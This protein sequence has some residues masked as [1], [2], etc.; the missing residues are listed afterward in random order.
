[1]AV[2]YSGRRGCLAGQIVLQG[3]RREGKKNPAAGFGLHS[4]KTKRKRVVKTEQ[5]EQNDD[6]ADD[7][8]FPIIIAAAY[9]A[10]E[11]HRLYPG[12]A[13]TMDIMPRPPQM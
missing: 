3:L 1:M 9:N 13:I 2:I 5:T 11:L 6:V 10:T 4:S 8:L 7:N 12:P